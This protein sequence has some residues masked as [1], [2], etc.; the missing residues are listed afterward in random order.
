MNE[1]DLKERFRAL[2]LHLGFKSGEKFGTEIGVKKQTISAIEAEGRGLTRERIQVICDKWN[3]D[4]RYFFGQI[5]NVEDADINLRDGND[6]LTLI[7]K[8]TRRI[9]KLTN[10]INELQTKV[11][12]KEKLDL[13]TDRV[14]VNTRLREIV[15]KFYLEPGNILNEIEV[16]INMYYGF[17]DK[18]PDNVNVEFSPQISEEDVNEGVISK[19]IQ[20]DKEDAL[21]K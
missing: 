21:A 5:D 15:S 7:E 20:L 17:K 6:R 1:E 9:E 10:Q 11:N 12:P 4:P 18:K 19:K 8:L 3:I 16:A 14:R 13:V 2:R